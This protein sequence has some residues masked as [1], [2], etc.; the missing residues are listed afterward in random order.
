MP[1]PVETAIRNA[2]D[3]PTLSLPTSAV[4]VITTL[5]IYGGVSMVHDVS[6]ASPSTSSRFGRPSRRRLRLRPRPPS[7]TPMRIH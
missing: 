1:D 5:T 2:A 3:R 7:S 6:P 4:A